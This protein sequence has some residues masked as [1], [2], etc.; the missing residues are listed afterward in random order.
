MRIQAVEVMFE[1][2]MLD[3]GEG[4]AR[5]RV[6]QSLVRRWRRKMRA[7]SLAWELAQLQKLR[8]SLFVMPTVSM[9]H[10]RAAAPP[11]GTSDS[12]RGWFA[13]PFVPGRC[14]RLVASR[15]WRLACQHQARRGRQFCDRPA[16]WQLGRHASRPMVPAR[17]GDRR[18]AVAEPSGVIPH[19]VRMPARGIDGSGT[20]GSRWR[21]GSTGRRVAVGRE[22][23][24]SPGQGLPASRSNYSTWHAA[25]AHDA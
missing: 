4:H 17:P 8:K 18:Q 25:V 7:M 16:P 11:A 12:V 20:S 6:P 1:A 19:Q 9:R 13:S 22:D 14:P 5:D 15:D 23:E 3:V 24:L 2:L 21:R 10:I